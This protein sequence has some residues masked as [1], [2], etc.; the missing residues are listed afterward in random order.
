MPREF[1]HSHPQFADLIRIVA[2]DRGIAS[3]LVE[4]DHWIMQRV[5]GL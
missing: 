1:L 5:Y 4:K 3:A 2:D